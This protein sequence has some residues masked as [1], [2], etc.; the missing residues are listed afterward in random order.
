[1][2]SPATSSSPVSY[3][4]YFGEKYH[5]IKR[6]NQDYALLVFERIQIPKST[7]NYDFFFFFT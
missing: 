7:W 1:M 6:L 4:V 3:G 5:A 2:D